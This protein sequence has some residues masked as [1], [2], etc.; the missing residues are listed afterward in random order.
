MQILSEILV[1]LINCNSLNLQNPEKLPAHSR[2][3]NSPFFMKFD[4]SLPSL[5]QPV[6]GS[7]PKPHISV[8][9]LTSYFLKSI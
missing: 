3:R 2:S 1:I 6:T 8:S 4:G 9:V 7:Y 5:R